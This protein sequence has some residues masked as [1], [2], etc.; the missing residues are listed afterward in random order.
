MKT[1]RK[2]R[3]E[4]Q[5]WTQYQGGEWSEEVAENTRR[6]ALQ[7]RREYLENTSGL[8]GI[9]IIKKRVKI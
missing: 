4:W 3:D 9:K 7:R 2:T 1:P 8:T 6:E 5:I